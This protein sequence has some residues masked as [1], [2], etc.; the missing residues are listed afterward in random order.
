MLDQIDE[1]GCGGTV[2]R[3]I[4]SVSVQEVSVRRENEISAE[5]QHVLSGL[6]TVWLPASEDES[7]VSHE[8]SPPEKHRP[9]PAFQPEVAV[10]RPAGVTHRRQRERCCR[11]RF[12]ARLCYDQ[13]V[14][15]VALY[16][17]KTFSHLHEVRQAGDSAQ[18]AKEYEQQRTGK[19]RKAGRGA[20]ETKERQVAHGVADIE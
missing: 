5:L 4:A 9:P 19:L 8:H 1:V 15:P 7:Q 18:V 16:N 13:H 11:Y 2:G 6:P 17:V 3:I 20:V 14:R 10:G 12:G